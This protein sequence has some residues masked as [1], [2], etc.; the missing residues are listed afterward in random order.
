MIYNVENTIEEKDNVEEIPIDN[1]Q[2]NIS[3][4]NEMNNQIDNRCEWIMKSGKNKGER[5]NKIKCKTHNKPNNETKEETKTIT[6]TTLTPNTSPTP[7][8][9]T[10]TTT[11]T[12]NNGCDWVMTRGKNK[13]ERCS[14]KTNNG[15]NRC[16]KHNK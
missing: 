6:P 15:G 1:I 10:H 3:I 11:P 14:S 13:G 5:C 9:Q 8:I 12:T 4:L 2:P 7:T 16:N